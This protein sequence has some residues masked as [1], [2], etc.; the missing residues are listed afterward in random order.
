[1]TTILALGA[2]CWLCT[3]FVVESELFKPLRSWTRER[4][5]IA[6]LGHAPASMYETASRNLQR[7]FNANTAAV[8]PWRFAIWSKVNYL[9]GCHLCAGTWIALGIV[10]VQPDARPLGTGFIGWLMAGLLVKAVAHLIL[11]G[12][13]AAKRF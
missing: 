3:T 12:V 5:L 4:K 13:A 7:A 11:E 9:V 1:M 10:T 2:V 6:D 8:H